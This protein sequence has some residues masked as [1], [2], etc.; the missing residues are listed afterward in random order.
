MIDDQSA[1]GVDILDIVN[2]NFFK[3]ICLADFVHSQ[4]L[5]VS[6]CMYTCVCVCVC[7]CVRVLVCVCVRVCVCVFVCLCV[8][9][10]V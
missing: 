9:V 7:I 4:H 10:C 2:G 3:Q 5:C 1:R 6:L 8:C